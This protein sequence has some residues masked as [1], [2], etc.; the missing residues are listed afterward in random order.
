MSGVEGVAALD[1]ETGAEREVWRTA[2]AISLEL[3]GVAKDGSPLVE[4]EWVVNRKI[5][6]GLFKG[7]EH[8]FQFADLN[9]DT[10]VSP[11]G[12]RKPEHRSFR[13]LHHR[14]GDRQ[15]ARADRQV[16]RAGVVAR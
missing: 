13:R 3:I 8:P 5:L 12:E 14:Y 9:E 10:T 4:K 15:A 1:L 11:G 2:G 6:S 7:G 16:R